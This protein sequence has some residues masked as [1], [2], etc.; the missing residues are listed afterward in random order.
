MTLSS[1]SVMDLISSL[2]THQSGA[3]ATGNTPNLGVP[4]LGD[5]DFKSHIGY[6]SALTICCVLL[7]I[8]LLWRAK[9]WPLL[10]LVALG[11]IPFYIVLGGAI[12]TPKYMYYMIPFLC[13]PVVY[14]LTSIP[15]MS[16]Q[17]RN[18]IVLAVVGLFTVQYLIGL[19]AVFA[20]KPSSFSTVNASG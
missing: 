6:F 10:A 11:C 4:L 13:I 12:T 15:A 19:R 14:A 3:P 16:G 5:A 20:S 7:G 1:A 17:L 18:L 8:G 9:Q 2:T